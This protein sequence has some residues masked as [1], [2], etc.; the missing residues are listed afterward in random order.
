VAVENDYNAP[1]SSARH[2]FLQRWRRR[3]P[4]FPWITSVVGAAIL[5]A[6]A[7]PS[8][9]REGGWY[10]MA[11]WLI[12]IFVAFIGLLILPYV[13]AY[14]LLH[15]EPEEI[16]NGARLAQ[17]VMILCVVWMWGWE[18]SKDLPVDPGDSERP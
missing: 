9:V 11:Y 17:V 12:L 2:T 1:A 4:T 18:P 5:T 7:S 10:F 8:G 16:I 14:F 3:P 13:F 15:D 6:A